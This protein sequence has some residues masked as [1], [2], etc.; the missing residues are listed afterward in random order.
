[1]VDIVVLIYRDNMFNFNCPTKNYRN[2]HGSAPMAE[3]GERWKPPDPENESVILTFRNHP[4]VGGFV[5]RGGQ[6]Q[7]GK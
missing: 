2:F 1:M 4:F 7:E 3:G 6:R 5:P